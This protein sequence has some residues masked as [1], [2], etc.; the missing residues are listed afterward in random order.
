LRERESTLAENTKTLSDKLTLLKE[1]NISSQNSHD[2][3]IQTLKNEHHQQLKAR[4]NALKE[5]FLKN[6]NLVN[7]SVVGKHRDLAEA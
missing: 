5:D 3:T 7:D 1:V 2:A 6:L 4:E